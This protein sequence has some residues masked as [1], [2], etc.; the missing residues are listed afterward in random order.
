MIFSLFGFFFS[1]GLSCNI[2]ILE[3]EE[4]K[5]LIKEK[6][7][8]NFLGFPEISGI[9]KKYHELPFGFDFSSI[10]SGWSQCSIEN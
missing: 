4:Q 10:L 2:V 9:L 3:N 5:K 1:F 8:S 7:Q 6:L